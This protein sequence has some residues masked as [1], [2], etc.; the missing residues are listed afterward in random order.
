[1][2][3]DVFKF[4]H[5]VVASSGLAA[6]LLFAVP[7]FAKDGIR[8]PRDHTLKI[9]G[10]VP[11]LMQSTY[12]WNPRRRGSGVDVAFSIHA[13]LPDFRPLGPTNRSLG[14]TVEGL[15]F[16]FQISVDKPISPIA[17]GFKNFNCSASPTG[18]PAELVLA[19]C[20][21]TRKATF[22]VLFRDSKFIGFVICNDM[23]VRATRCDL[24]A[25]HRK[26]E[27][28]V[29]FSRIYLPEINSILFKVEKLLDSFVDTA[30]SAGSETL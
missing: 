4:V 24:R 11:Y 23:D 20:N 27:M 14:D 28:L 12:I 6:L 29:S 1:M 17:D 3:S 18:V 15:D 16:M 25:P 21:P 7:S 9:V 5:W 13:Y 30:I 19:V 26:N 2:R 10:G 8:I 22:F